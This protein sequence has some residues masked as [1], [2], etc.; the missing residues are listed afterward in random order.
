MK[1]T[2]RSKPASLS[3]WRSSTH[4]T[5]FAATGSP[6]DAASASGVLPLALAHQ[7]DRL[8]HL[9]KIRRQR[10]GRRRGL[11][12][13]M[14]AVRHLDLGLV[15]LAL[16]HLAVLRRLAVRGRDLVVLDRDRLLPVMRRDMLVAPGGHRVDRAERRKR[17]ARSEQRDHGPPAHDLAAGLQLGEYVLTPTLEAGEPVPHGVPLP[18]TQPHCS[19]D[20]SRKPP[21][22]RRRLCPKWAPNAPVPGQVRRILRRDAASAPQIPLAAAVSPPS[23]RISAAVM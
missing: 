19:R 3:A 1:A 8:F 10:L 12:D 20:P 17:H 14:L 18:T 11:H 21:Q 22:P 9:C 6:I 13:Q 16:G 4:S 5:S 15:V 7:L 2:W 23:T